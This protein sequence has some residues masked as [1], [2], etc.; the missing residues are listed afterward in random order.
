MTKAEFL[1]LKPGDKI[2][3]NFCGK[4]Y[5]TVKEVGFAAIRVCWHD[6]SYRNSL[7]PLSLEECHL[8]YYSIDRR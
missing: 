5:G 7:I 8:K 6:S 3:N 1:N 2:I 4:T